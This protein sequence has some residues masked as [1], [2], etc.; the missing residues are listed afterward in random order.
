MKMH[1]DGSAHTWKVNREQSCRLFAHLGKHALINV[2]TMYMCDGSA[3]GGQSHSWVRA[4]IG[5]AGCSMRPAT[6]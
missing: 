6:P 1:I 4:Q 3:S 5:I 2:Y